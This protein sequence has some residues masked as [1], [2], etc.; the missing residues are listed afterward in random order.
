L[1]AFNPQYFP[2]QAQVG[3]MRASVLE[4]RQLIAAGALPNAYRPLF[5][6]AEQQHLAITT[7]YNAILA[8]NPTLPPPSLA[9]VS[10]RFNDV[11]RAMPR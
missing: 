8:A 5:V 2:M 3:A 11:A 7:I 6:Q 9:K 1:M 4:M 10:G